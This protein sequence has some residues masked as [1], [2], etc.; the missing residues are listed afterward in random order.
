[1][2]PAAAR[3]APAAGARPAA[4]S[5]APGV[6]SA[7][8][9]GARRRWHVPLALVALILLGGTFIALLQPAATPAGY[10]DP[11]N[12]GPGGARALADILT[13]RGHIISRVTTP[14]AAV[15][16]VNAA[17]AGGAT[18][19]VTSPGFLS[20]G[21]LAMLARVPGEVILVAPDRA[22]LAALA[23]AVT[24][25]GH[26]PVQALPPACG[27]TA[28]RLA[29]SAGMGGELLRTTAA[30]ATACY[31]AAGLPSLVRYQAAGKVIT[32]LGTGMPLAN[33]NLA[34]L[35][36]AALAVSLLS[37]RQRIVWLVP[38]AAPGA[39]APG[40]PQSLTSLIPL[41]AYLVAIQLAIAALLA[42]L[43]RARRLGPLAAEPL[44]VVIRASE[45]V[46]GHARLYQARRARGR[47]AAALRAAAVR[48]MAAGL[49]LTPADA[50]GAIV[51]ALAGRTGTSAA[52]VEALL[53]GADPGDDAALVELAGDLD[54]LE[55]EVRAH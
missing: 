39:A 21:Q 28:A 31:P 9:G 2:A 4:G 47:A 42:A 50:P 7:G 3:S 45:T 5:P 49:G 18:L 15:N 38:A 12:T 30:G 1:M 10:L 48:R 55:R 33:G 32:V 46:E 41:P 22:A 53:F 19:L 25:G 24:V 16:A 27:L 8:P 29:G 6:L 14:A 26:A 51:A 44:P 34:R 52:R 23:P 40:T 54:V 13:G 11:G 20:R 35:G 37:P 17:G 36:N 43:W